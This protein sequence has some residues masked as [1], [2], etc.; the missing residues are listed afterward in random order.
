[1]KVPLSARCH[2]QRN[3]ALFCG[4]SKTRSVPRTAGLPMFRPANT[5]RPTQ[6]FVPH[7][8]GETMAL[9]SKNLVVLLGAVVLMVALAGNSPAQTVVVAPAPRVAYY[10]PPTVVSYYAAPVCYSP[11]PVASYYSPPAISY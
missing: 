11:A 8:G 1:M 2:A 5:M 9:I 7:T 3:A 10:A 4:R 6:R